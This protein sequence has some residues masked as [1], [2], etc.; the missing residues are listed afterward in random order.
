MCEE[1][2][3]NARIIENAANIVLPDPDSYG[4]DMIYGAIQNMKSAARLVVDMVNNEIK[5]TKADD[6]SKN[7]GH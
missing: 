6:E 5:E 2:L 1:K 3:N 4:M 7:S